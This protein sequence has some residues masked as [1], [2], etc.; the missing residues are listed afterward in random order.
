MK[1]SVCRFTCFSDT[2]LFTNRFK[3]LFSK[4]NTEILIIID[5]LPDGLINEYVIKDKIHSENVFLL[6]LVLV[7]GTMFLVWLA[8]QNTRYGIAGPMPIVM[9]S[10][11]NDKITLC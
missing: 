1:L 9:M 3:R 10:I 2:K 5:I 7:T 8:D 6:L 11:V 4:T